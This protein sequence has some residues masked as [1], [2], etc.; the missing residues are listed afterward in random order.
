MKWQGSWAEIGSGHG[1]RELLISGR[2][3]MLTVILGKYSS[4]K[5]LC[6]PELGAGSPL[7]H[8]SDVFWNFEQ[9]ARLICRTDAAT[10]AYALADYSK[11]QTE[12]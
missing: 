5:C 9:L 1:C 3:T 8:L 10:I 11:H 2:G 7:S 6:I 4:G 12:L